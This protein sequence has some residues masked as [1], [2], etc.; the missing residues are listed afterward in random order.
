M[1]T[2]LID[3]SLVYAGHKI[4]ALADIYTRPRKQSVAHKSK[5][6]FFGMDARGIR[7]SLQDDT[8]DRYNLDG[9]E[10]LKFGKEFYKLSFVCTKTS[11]ARVRSTI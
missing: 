1:T 4:H 6:Q 2:L 7:I 9:R 3:Y 11:A 8:E 5:R 10:V